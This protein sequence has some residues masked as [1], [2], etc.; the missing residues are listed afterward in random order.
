MWENSSISSQICQLQDNY[1]VWI[2]VKKG[3]TISGPSLPQKAK[4]FPRLE[5]DIKE[6]LVFLT[7]LL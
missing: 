2:G 3:S 4:G 7:L 5:I 1:V 6:T